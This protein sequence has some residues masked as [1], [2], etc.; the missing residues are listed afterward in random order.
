MPSSKGSERARPLAPSRS[1]KLRTS[2]SIKR[3]FTLLS[4][5]RGDAATSGGTHECHARVCIA[6]PVELD[7]EPL[8]GPPSLRQCSH[9]FFAN[10][11]SWLNGNCVMSDVSGTVLSPRVD[12]PKMFQ[13]EIRQRH[14][15]R[16]GPSNRTGVQVSQTS[17]S[18]QITP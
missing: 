5:A 8:S 6:F 13:L 16:L 1:A 7:Q 17:L 12:D 15:H 11:S 3:S 9:F 18:C 2:N 4:S 10:I 14:L